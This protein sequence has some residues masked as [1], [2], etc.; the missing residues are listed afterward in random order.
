MK[1]C[2]I[3]EDLD[4][5]EEMVV[6]LFSG[7]KNKNVTAPNWPDHPYGPKQL[8]MKGLIVPVKDLRNLNIIFAIPDLHDYKDFGV[9]FYLVLLNIIFGFKTVN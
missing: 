7:V 9:S 2:L 6:N 5:L 8:Q 1:N 4:T 3:S